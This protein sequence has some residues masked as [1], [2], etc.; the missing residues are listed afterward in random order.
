MK[1]ITELTSMVSQEYLNDIKLSEKQ[2][3]TTFSPIF[4]SLNI[5]QEEINPSLK[6]WNENTTCMNTR[7]LRDYTGMQNYT[8]KNRQVQQKD[9]LIKI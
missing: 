8:P 4:T 2:D 5:K 6:I 7:D 9:M 3:P 1:T